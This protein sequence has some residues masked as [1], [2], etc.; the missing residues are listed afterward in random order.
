MVMGGDVQKAVGEI[1]AVQKRRF[2]YYSRF[3]L[4]KVA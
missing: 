4:I 3:Y 1:E 2:L